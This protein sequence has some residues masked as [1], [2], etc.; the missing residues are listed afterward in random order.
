VGDQDIEKFLLNQ[1]LDLQ[2]VD[3]GIEKGERRLEIELKIVKIKAFIVRDFTGR[4]PI[5]YHRS[6]RYYFTIYFCF[7]NKWQRVFNL[8]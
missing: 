6:I 7:Q 5:R 8:H 2:A 3:Q 4:K 1:K